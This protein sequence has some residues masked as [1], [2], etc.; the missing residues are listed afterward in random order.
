MLLCFYRLLLFAEVGFPWV[1]MFVCVHQSE[2][3]E[4]LSQFLVALVPRPSAASVLNRCEVYI[5]VFAGDAKR[6]VA[7]FLSMYFSFVSL[8]WVQRTTGEKTSCYEARVYASC[9]LTLR[10]PTT[11]RLMLKHLWKSIAMLRVCFEHYGYTL[12]LIGYVRVCV[13]VCGSEDVAG[14]YRGKCCP[15]TKLAEALRR[16]I[17]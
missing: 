6:V 11:W 9:T 1:A 12:Y 15:R 13:C 5:H 7:L 14:C 3:I 2:F 16:N 10:E 8:C 4:C 17:T